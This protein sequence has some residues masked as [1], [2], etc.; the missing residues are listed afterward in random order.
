[1]NA[2]DLFPASAMDSTSPR[3]NWLMKHNL[4]IGVLP[5]GIKFCVG[6]LGVGLGDTTKDA[7]LEFTAMYN[8]DAA[9]NNT[10][11]IEHWSVVDARK[12]GIVMPGDAQ[13]TEAW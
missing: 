3:I 4:A 8:E 7:E 6:E 1:M 11:T 10:S 5:N 9:E 13:A 12:A 2:P